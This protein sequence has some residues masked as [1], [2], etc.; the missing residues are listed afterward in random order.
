MSIDN[1][2]KDGS[3]V[4]AQRYWKDLF[5]SRLTK[6]YV[7]EGVNQAHRSRKIF[8]REDDVSIISLKQIDTIEGIFGGEAYQ[9]GPLTVE[10]DKT[11]KEIELNNVPTKGF[12][13]FI[14]DLTH[15]YKTSNL[16]FTIDKPFAPI[17]INHENMNV[18]VANTSPNTFAALLTGVQDQL[19]DS[20]LADKNKQTISYV[21]TPAI[22]QNNLQSSKISFVD[23][24]TYKQLPT[25]KDD[26]EITSIEIE[27]DHSFNPEY[28]NWIK[29]KGDIESRPGEIEEFDDISFETNEALMPIQI[30]P[31]AKS[32]KVQFSVKEL[33]TKMVM[34]WIYA[35]QFLTSDRDIQTYITQGGSESWKKE[36][37]TAVVDAFKMAHA[38]N[39]RFREYRDPATGEIL[40]EQIGGISIKAF[41]DKP[42]EASN[43]VSS[44]IKNWEY[45]NFD[46]INSSSLIRAKQILTASSQW[47]PSE[48]SVGKETTQSHKILLPFY[49]DLD[50]TVAKATTKINMS[51]KSLRY[52]FDNYDISNPKIKG[53][54]SDNNQSSIK[55]DTTDRDSSIP[56]LDDPI[57]ITSFSNFP[58]DIDTRKEGSF[59]YFIGIDI[60]EP[61]DLETFLINSSTT[62]ETIKTVST[63]LDTN[64]MV[65]EYFLLGNIQVHYLGQT[66]EGI[67][68]SKTPF[69]YWLGA[70][71]T[72]L[73]IDKTLE[74]Q[75]ILFASN[76]PAEAYDIQINNLGT[77]VVKKDNLIPGDTGTKEI[78]L[79]RY[80]GV[81]VEYKIKQTING[82][83][84]VP[85]FFDKTTWL[86]KKLPFAKQ[87]TFKRTLTP[88][89]N[90]TDD[91]KIKSI[92]RL[93]LSFFLGNFINITINYKY[94]DSNGVVQTGFS[95]IPTLDL[96]SKYDETRT[97][98]GIRI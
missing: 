86:K 83:D 67:K 32:G 61:D 52:E 49:L 42:E 30:E 80:E 43:A 46:K 92:S 17:D 11:I 97:K 75:A 27:T 81:V 34:P 70:D 19:T 13:A 55:I 29:A 14:E 7:Y 79:I 85:R 59:K 4:G 90:L 74:P 3:G 69:I 6:L 87:P 72:N 16:Y 33:N 25:E 26:F 93:W 39:T 84:A 31:Y 38:F 28:G 57:S 40:D 56:E 45:Q 36:L 44:I 37:S 23:S 5:P 51:L 63:S 8:S 41:G 96:P 15:D 95:Q 76:I 48:W 54:I 22:L 50:S 58:G 71:F 66:F 91:Q 78:N 2:S 98:F 18:F 1:I 12:T 24:A 47:V 53:L 9:V 60:N 82:P 10:E 77:K 64:W 94:K 21:L 88:I 73:D 68:V 62:K 20:M 35:K 89:K 65:P